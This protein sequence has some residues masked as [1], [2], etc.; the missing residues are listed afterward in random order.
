MKKGRARVERY[1]KALMGDEFPLFQEWLTKPL[2][3]SLRVNTIKADRKWILSRLQDAGAKPKQIPWCE[4]GFW[5]E[6]RPWGATFLHQLGFIYM[7]GAASMLPAELL[8]PEMGDVVLDLAAAPGSKTTQLAPRCDTVVAN[9]P[10]YDRRKMLFSNLYR[11]GVSNCAVTHYDGR[12]F[13]DEVEFDK[14]LLDAPCSD[15]GVARR[16]ESILNTWSEGRAKRTATLQKQLLKNAFNLL[17]PGGE[18][19]YSTC[20]TTLEENEEVVF[21]LLDYV[22]EA[23]LVRIGKRSKLK[24]R[25]GLLPGTEDCMRVYPWDNDTEF[26]FLAKFKN[27]SG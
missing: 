3:K 14:I 9:E 23:E 12:S 11:C 27:G 26:F 20:T 25:P 16:R 22:P 13:P 2:K 1:H 24:S 7:Q 18:L 4:E 19:V 17:K 6:N 10:V 21:E 5:V 15:I 8:A